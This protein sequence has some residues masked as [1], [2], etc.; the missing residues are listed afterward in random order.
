MRLLSFCISDTK[1]FNSVRYYAHILDKKYANVMQYTKNGYEKFL[2][3][4]LEYVDILT[5]NEYIRYLVLE[6]HKM[7]LPE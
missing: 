2:D 4:D 3:I 6:K 7:N 5:D 1:P